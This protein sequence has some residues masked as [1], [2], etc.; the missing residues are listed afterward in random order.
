[1]DHQYIPF[2]IILQITNQ[3]PRALLAFVLCVHYANL[4]TRKA[5]LTKA[6]VDQKHNLSWTKFK[7]DLRSLSS[8]GLLEWNQ[9]PKGINVEVYDFETE[10][11]DD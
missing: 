4:H 1:M 9:S 6:I 10:S 2:D 7:N 5:H 3:H 8:I 11:E